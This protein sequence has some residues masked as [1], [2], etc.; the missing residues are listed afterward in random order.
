MST[1]LEVIQLIKRGRGYDECE[2]LLLD[3]G[4]HSDKT[5]PFVVG[6]SHLI[7][8]DPMF[9]D[10]AKY[11]QEL[12]QANEL[13]EQFLATDDVNK[14]KAN[15]LEKE[16]NTLLRTNKFQAD[17][18]FVLDKRHEAAVA[19]ANLWKRLLIEQVEKDI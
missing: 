18:Y 12:D 11:K 6:L 17:E 10:L 19:A 5:M 9:D 8:D 13:N 15:K 4:W 7:A 2:K 14:I 3:D 1:I 16:N